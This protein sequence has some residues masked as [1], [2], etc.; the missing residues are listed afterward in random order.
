MAYPNLIQTMLALAPN[1]DNVVIVARAFVEFTGSL[2]AGLFLS[3]MLYWTPRAK[4]PDGFIAKSDEEWQEELCLTRYGVRK[5]R[6]TLE[7]MEVLETKLKKWDGAPTTHYR[8]DQTELHKQWI[9]WI[10]TNDCPNSDNPTSDPEQSLT[11]TTPETTS[12]TTTDDECREQARA[13]HRPS[14]DENDLDAWQ[15]KMDGADDDYFDVPE[16]EEEPERR[17]VATFDPFEYTPGQDQGPAPELGDE[18]KEYKKRMAPKG[19]FQKAFLKAL[20]D[21]RF[22]PGIK[23]KLNAL[24]RAIQRGKTLGTD[25]YKACVDGL[26]GH[27]PKLDPHALPP[28]PESWW[29]FKREHAKQHARH[30]SQEMFISSLLDHDNILQHCRIRISE[31]GLEERRTIAERDTAPSRE[32]EKFFREKQ[33]ANEDSIR[34]RLAQQGIDYDEILEEYGVA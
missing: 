27:P 14:K 3:Q 26:A 34:E 30:W 13:T 16:E 9:D 8:L 12:D 23:S 25:V 11:E 17:A 32:Q 18:Y 31:L 2:E 20:G 5:A 6:K 29:F 1:G 21:K 7:E 28:I 24:A 19:R 10:D 15:L 33:Q 4:R 22:K